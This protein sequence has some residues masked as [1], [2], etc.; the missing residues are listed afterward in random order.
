M[1]IFFLP[2]DV[3]GKKR[4]CCVHIA[5]VLKTIPNPCSDMAKFRNYFQDKCKFYIYLLQQSVAI[6]LHYFMAAVML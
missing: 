5:A 4:Q 6:F 3:T 1:E 2:P